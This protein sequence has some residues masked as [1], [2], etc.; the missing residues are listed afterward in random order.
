MLL[1]IIYTMYISQNFSKKESPK[2]TSSENFFFILGFPRCIFL[3]MTA[4]K[5]TS[6][7]DAPA[8]E[9]A[10]AELEGVTRQ[11]E[12]GDLTLDQAL[13]RFESGIGLL[14][15]CDKHL[16]ATKGRLLE[17]LKDE[18]NEFITN[19]LGESLESFTDTG[20]KGDTGL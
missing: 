16:T 14:R 9:D 1:N 13:A 11:L 18:K 12:R 19:I 7:P 2:K 8:F 6:P 20:E 15:S 10:L 4:K 5:K 17:L 3:Y